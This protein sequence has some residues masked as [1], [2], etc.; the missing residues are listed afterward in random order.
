MNGKTFLTTTN[1]GIGRA[2]PDAQ[3][4]WAVETHLGAQDVRCLAADPLQP[5]V[6]YAGTQ[7]QGVF[8][9]AD[10]GRTWQQAGLAGQVVKA[11]AASPHQPGLLYAGTRP[12][13]LY[14]SAD[15][16]ASW[17][18][19]HGFR[20]IPN[21]R[22]WFSPAEKP[23]TAYVQAIALSPT[24]PGVMLAGIEFGAVVRSVDHGRTWSGHRSGSLRD[25]H[26][27]T[28]H[29]AQ[30]D[31][32]YEAGGTGGGASFSRD[33]GQNWQKA[34]SGLAKPYGVACA[35]DPL[36]PEVWYLSVAPSPGKAYGAEPEAY[37]YRA[38]GGAGWEPCGWHD[39]PMTQ[40]PIAL[41]TDPTAPGHLFAATTAGQV[42]HTAD[43]GDSWSQLP[44]TFSSAWRSLLVL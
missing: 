7:G 14:T 42:W 43:Y 3:G 25:C 8:R 33:A 36:R 38:A 1:Q 29:T 22:W 21:R 13:Y 31:W 6:V 20:Q 32:A 44:F 5:G 19:L 9:S 18:E 26:S 16:G 15:S 23:F 2:A 12:A 27:L 11:L 37:L 41:A 4:G 35:A 34:K 24:E 30:G 17:S 10:Y 40:M 39:L 28:F